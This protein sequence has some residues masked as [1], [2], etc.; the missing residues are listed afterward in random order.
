MHDD[1]NAVSACIKQFVAPGWQTTSLQSVAPIFT[2]LSDSIE[3]HRM[4]SVVSDVRIEFAGQYSHT[5]PGCVLIFPGE[6][7]KHSCEKKETFSA[8]ECGGEHA[9]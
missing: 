9:W 8:H 2:I 4:H 3:V 7:A 6:H 1:A 5:V